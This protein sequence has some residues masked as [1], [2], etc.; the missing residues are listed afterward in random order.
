MS[1]QLHELQTLLI[2]GG[3]NAMKY[4]SQLFQ[5]STDSDFNRV[6]TERD[7]LWSTDQ[8]ENFNWGQT[9]RYD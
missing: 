8:T 6:M 9:I 4:V 5:V 3:T 2:R 1:I 7:I